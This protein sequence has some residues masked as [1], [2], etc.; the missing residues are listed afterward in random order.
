M[1]AGLLPVAISAKSFRP[2]SK[3]SRLML[4]ASSLVVVHDLDIPCR[5]FSPFEAYPPSIVDP[6][7]VLSAS[8]AVQSFEAIA[9]Q[10]P[11]IVEPFG[12][13]DGEKLRSRPPLNLVR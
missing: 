9:R 8:I 5:A 7:A 12:R 2:A 1:S 6:H 4:I 13:I 3:S 10:S 11:Q